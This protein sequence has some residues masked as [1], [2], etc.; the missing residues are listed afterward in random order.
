[1]QVHKLIGKYSFQ[2]IISI[3]P[4][5]M[6][7]WDRWGSTRVSFILGVLGITRFQVQKLVGKIQFFINLRSFPRIYTPIGATAMVLAFI[8]ATTSMQV[9]Q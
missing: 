4:G 9:Y 5:F 7:L 2:T 8:R 1:M 6:P 3:F